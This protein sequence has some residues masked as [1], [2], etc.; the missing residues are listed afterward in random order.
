MKF[1]RLESFSCTVMPVVCSS[2]LAT[3][4]R[5]KSSMRSRVITVTDCGVSR[6]DSGSLAA[7]SVTL[8]A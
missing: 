6:S 3:V 2:T 8:A 1:T 4:T 5:P 7:D